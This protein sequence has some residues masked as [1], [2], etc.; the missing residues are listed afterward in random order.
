MHSEIYVDRQFRKGEVDDRLYGSFIEHLGRAV[1]GG[2]YDPGHPT[3][4]L[5]GF[6]E[7]VIDLVKE[8]KVSVVRYPGGNFVSSYRW[9]DSVGPVEKRPV[10]LDLAWKSKEP[11]RIGI[12]EFAGWVKKTG[13][14]LMMAVNLGTRGVEDAAN[15]VEYCNHPGGTY[16]SDLR[17]QH[18]FEK[19]H[20]VR[21][22]CLGNEMDGPWQVGKKSAR[23]YGRL[24]NETAKALRYFDESLQLIVCGSSV[25][26]LPTF[27]QWEMEVLSECYENVDYLSLHMYMTNTDDD[28]SKYMASSL[29]MDRFIE[30]VIHVCDYI[31]AKKRSKKTIQLSFDEWNVWFHSLEEQA[32]VMRENPWQVGPPLLQDI[33]TFED[34]LVVGMM[35]NSLI[36]HADRVKIAC[37]AQLVNVIAP[38]MTENGGPVWKQSTYYPFYY[39]SRYGRGTA[40]DI[41]I[42]AP[43]YADEDYG[44]VP[45]LDSSVVHNAER[46]ELA[47]FAVNRSADDSLEIQF[48]L[49]GFEGYG[50]FLHKTMV[51]R[52]RKAVNTKDNPDNVVPVDG[53]G[54]D[55]VDG[56]MA[57]ELPP[58]SWNLLVLGKKT[59]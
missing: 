59:L 20:D 56:I 9:E 43:C 3:A 26:T 27:P 13:T 33:Y 58:L 30:T 23:E 36:R 46:E 35:L 31:K 28:L 54:I 42:D 55:F 24:A 22:W 16:W 8:L 12:N 53:A 10:R 15:L 7:D 32:K 34:A 11:N 5:D 18:G 19:P 14:E 29:G 21:L 44:E 52:D 41:R 38:I 1:Y 48:H 45:Y 51:H 49:S 25:H 40:L 39:A 2:I 57:G 50:L 6:R 37:L 17:R 47:I 4:D